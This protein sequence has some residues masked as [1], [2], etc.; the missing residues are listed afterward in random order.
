MKKILFVFLC[1]LTVLSV[2]VFAEEAKDAG[3]E[4]ARVDEK[5]FQTT[6]DAVSTAT[7]VAEKAEADGE[8][9]ETAAQDKKVQ[10]KICHH[11]ITLNANPYAFQHIGL[12]NDDTF[13]SQ[14][15]F[16]VN[17][18]YRY[19]FGLFNV[20]VEAGYN[21]FKYEDFERYHILS[22]TGMGGISYHFNPKFFLDGDL[23][24]GVDIRFMDGESRANVTTLFR[25]NA[26]YWLNDFISLTGGADLKLSWQHHET[27]DLK[28]TD[29][30]VYVNVGTKISL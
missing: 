16:G 2:N 3:A 5:A 27:D 14:Y 29:L 11:F 7:P 21:N 1:L 13:N 30:G 12:R 6:E 19:S 25:L 15:G 18:G 26:G 10:Y 4:S 8:A 24:C 9:A 17:L 23:G 28:S 20:G 22:F